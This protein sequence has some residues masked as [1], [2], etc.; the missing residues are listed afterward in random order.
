LGRSFTGWTYPTMPGATLAKHNPSYYGGPMV[1]FESNH[2][3][4]A[5]TF[6]GQS[7]A[8]GQSAEQE[9]ANVLTIIFNN[10]NLPPFVCQQLI[11]K[12]VTSNPSPAY[13][14]RVTAAFTSGKFQSYGSG[15]RGD[16]QA[17]AAAILLDDEARRGD[18]Q[19]TAVATDG[20]LRE[21]VVMMLGLARAFHAT[22]DGTGFTGQGGNMSQS[23]FNSG[24]VFNFF[25][26]ESLIPGTTL[27]GPEFA[28]FNTSTALNRVNFINTF[29]Y[30]KLSSTTTVDFTPVINAGTPDQMVTWLNNLFLHG[31]MSSQMQ[32]SISTALGAVSSTDTTNQAKT[33]IYLVTSSSQYQVQR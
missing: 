3:S 28:I 1:P 11:E 31:T 26:P 20:K 4:G 27:N 15:K 16:M 32:S 5:K 33:A 18:S 22:T 23:L 8:A 10:S 9:L 6:L 25:P 29:V 12:L 14:A 19:T 2:D 24:S 30:G 21:P 7:V 17:V 13:V